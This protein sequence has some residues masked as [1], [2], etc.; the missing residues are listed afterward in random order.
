M[1]TG[2]N[3]YPPDLIIGSP[4]LPNVRMH[5]MIPPIAIY[6]LALVAARS[7]LPAII[8]SNDALSVYVTLDY[9]RKYF[10]LNKRNARVAL[11]TATTKGNLIVRRKGNGG[12]KFRE[13][14]LNVATRPCGS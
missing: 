11:R 13:K 7:Q 5:N 10:F 9:R 8:T 3:A 6:S 12:G 14:K 2:K 4:C 1:F